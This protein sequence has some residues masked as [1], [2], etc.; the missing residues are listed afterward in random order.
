MPKIDAIIKERLF[1]LCPQLVLNGF[2]RI[3]W[4]W[5][6]DDMTLYLQ[7]LKNNREMFGGQIKYI[8]VYYFGRSLGGNCNFICIDLMRKMY[9]EEVQEWFHMWI[10]MWWRKFQQRVELRLNKETKRR[11][12]IV[13]KTNKGRSF[14]NN[15]LNQKER[16]FLFKNAMKTL[17]NNGEIVRPEIIV[18]QQIF[19]RL[20]QKAEKKD[21]TV[22]DIINF[23]KGLRDTLKHLSRGDITFLFVFPSKQS[24]VE[25]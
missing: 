22:E 18:K 3:V 25:N 20:S 11:S 15:K 19:T 5:C 4:M 7:H 13:K 16:E 23:D 1:E 6:R 9:E 8:E 2:D 17:I 12:C 14:W 24:Y 21:W 10:R